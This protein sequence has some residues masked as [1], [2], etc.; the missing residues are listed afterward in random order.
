MSLRLPPPRLSLLEDAVTSILLLPE[1]D[2]L[3]SPEPEQPLQSGRSRQ[4]RTVSVWRVHRSRSRLHRPRHGPWH[5]LER[6]GNERRL[7][8]LR[9]ERRGHDLVEKPVNRLSYDTGST[10]RLR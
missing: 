5:P 8:Q 10:G 9:E 4:T 1:A 7:G 6:E 3:A 2:W